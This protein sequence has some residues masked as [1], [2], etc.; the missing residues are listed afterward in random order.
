MIRTINSNF[1]QQVL[2]I[3]LKYCFQLFLSKYLLTHSWILPFKT[4]FTVKICIRILLD[5]DPDPNPNGL[6]RCGFRSFKK[7]GSFR[8]RLPNTVYNRI[9]CRWKPSKRSTMVPDPRQRREKDKFRILK[10]YDAL[11]GLFFSLKVHKMDFRQKKLKIF[12]A[13]VNEKASWLGYRYTFTLI[14]SGYA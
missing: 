6:I 13:L 4:C 1:F 8:I 2:I 5:P 9:L 11:R 12:L 10:T 7:F 3:G 14:G